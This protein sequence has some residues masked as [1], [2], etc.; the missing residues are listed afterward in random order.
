VC[1]PL[2]FLPGH[3]EIPADLKF[4]DPYFDSVYNQFLPQFW[5]TKWT[6][7]KKNMILTL[8]KVLGTAGWFKLLLAASA[9]RSKNGGFVGNRIQHVTLG[10]SCPFWEGHG[11]PNRR[12]LTSAPE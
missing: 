2:N 10:S 4:E 6:G 5:P 9:K 8:Y 12:K 3:S 11:Q 7:S 1:A